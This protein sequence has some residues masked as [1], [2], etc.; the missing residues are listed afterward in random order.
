MEHARH[1]FRVVLVLVVALAAILLGRG[2]LVPRSFGLYGPYR[3][4]NVAEQM[5]VRTPRHGGAESCTACHKPR[6]D[7]HAAGAHQRVSC[8]VCHA[9]LASHVRAG[10]KVAAMPVDRS[11]TLCARC[12]RRIAGRPAAFKQVDLEQHVPAKLEG[13]VC[14]DCHNPHS[15]KP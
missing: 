9:P 1:V 6:H 7:E 4:D 12:H 3:F 14:L 5:S 8:E 2:S 15:P 11:F 10:A 13:G